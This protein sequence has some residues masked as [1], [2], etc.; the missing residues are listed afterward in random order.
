MK[1]RDSKGFTLI[2]LLIVV[3]IIGIIAAIAVPGLLRARMS[4]NEAAA[5]G[6][7]R[8]INS[9]MST[10][11]SSCGSGFYAPS[12]VRLAAAPTVGGGDGFVGKDLS[13]DPSVKSSYTIT[14]TAGAAAARRRLL[15]RRGGRH[16]GLDLLGGCGPDGRRRRALLR[17]QPGQHDLPAHGSDDGGAERLPGFRHADRVTPGSNSFDSRMPAPSGGHPSFLT[18]SQIHPQR[19]RL[20]R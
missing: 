13:T 20:L 9:G 16:G 11:A 10:Y 8:A 15:Q 14:M 18:Q 19:R 2:E 17:L 3:A 7:L 4:G 6:S 12:L 5:I 1:L